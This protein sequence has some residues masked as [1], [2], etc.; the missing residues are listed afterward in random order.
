M[1]QWIGLLQTPQ[2]TVCF[3]TEQ[4][5]SLEHSINSEGKQ[6]ETVI[7]SDVFPC[8]VVIYSLPFLG[9]NDTLCWIFIA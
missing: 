8:A 4:G 3:P 9:L 5:F 2:E 1:I 7:I 6:M